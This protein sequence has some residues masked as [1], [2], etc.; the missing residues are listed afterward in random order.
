M[1]NPISVALPSGGMPSFVYG[2]LVAGVAEFLVLRWGFGLRGKRW[3]GLLVVANIVS[4]ALGGYPLQKGLPE[5][6]AKFDIS[7]L[8]FP[9]VLLGRSRFAAGVIGVRPA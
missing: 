2:N 1:L 7:P 9:I 4:A 3:L 6:L 5:A 8:S